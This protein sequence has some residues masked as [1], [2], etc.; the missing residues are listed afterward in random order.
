MIKAKPQG[1]VQ[2]SV[3]RSKLMLLFADDAVECK[4]KNVTLGAQST[5]C[6]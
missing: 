5:E 4:V 6:M 2:L 1:G 3:R